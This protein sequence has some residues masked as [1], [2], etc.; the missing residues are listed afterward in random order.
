MLRMLSLVTADTL[1]RVCQNQEGSSIA[2]RMRHKNVLAILVLFGP[3]MQDM[4]HRLLSTTKRPS[5]EGRDTSANLTEASAICAASPLQAGGAIV[6][7]AAPTIGSA[8]E[9]LKGL[10][11]PLEKEFGCRPFSSM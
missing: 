2:A 4:V 6:R 5:F 8:R 1:D 7:I 3:R 11:A 10:L 9:H